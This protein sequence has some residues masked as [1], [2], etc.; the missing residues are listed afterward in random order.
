MGFSGDG[1]KGEFGGGHLMELEVE[2]EELLN[3][4]AR[5]GLVY[6]QEAY[7]GKGCC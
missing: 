6:G 3:R 4:F 1:G 7:E 2:G 5:G